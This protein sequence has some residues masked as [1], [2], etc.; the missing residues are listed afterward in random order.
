MT[1]KTK[2][3]S[4]DLAKKVDLLL[5][6]DKVVQGIVVAVTEDGKEYIRTKGHFYDTAN[7]LNTVLNDF[8]EQ[9]YMDI[10]SGPRP[11]K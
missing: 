3:E 11:K 1:K 7:L 5:D 10:F 6:D 4:N 8:K 2:D 9:I